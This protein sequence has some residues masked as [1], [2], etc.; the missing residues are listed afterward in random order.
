MSNVNASVLEVLLVNVC[1]YMVFGLYLFYI[2]MAT[3][4]SYNARRLFDR[5]LNT[6]AYAH[7]L[8]E[9]MA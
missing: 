8:G 2:S 7:P 4:Y 1:E 3:V 9:T 6:G 5:E